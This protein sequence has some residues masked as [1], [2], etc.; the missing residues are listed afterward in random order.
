VVASIP[1]VR[2]LENIWNLLI[3][4]DWKYTEYGILD[5]THLRFFTLQ[6]IRVIF[7]NLGYH[8]ERI[9]GINPFDEKPYFKRLSKRFIY[10]VFFL[11]NLLFFKHIEDMRYLQ[12]VVVARPKSLWQ[13]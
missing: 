3:L 10:W 2:Y 11:T 1:N 5:R 12:F 6:S 9:E 4:K 8:I 7:E 13:S